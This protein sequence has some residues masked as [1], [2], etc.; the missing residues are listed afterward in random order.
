MRWDEKKRGGGGIYV[1]EGKDTGML[2]TKLVKHT[3]HESS[4]YSTKV[5]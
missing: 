5:Y 4:F 3:I 2:F 1:K